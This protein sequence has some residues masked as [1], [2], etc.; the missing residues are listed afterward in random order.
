MIRPQWQALRVGHHVLVHDEEMAGMPLVP[1]RVA[2]IQTDPNSN[3]IGIRITPTEGT[4]KI[5]RPRR[6]AVH[7]PQLDLDE[8]CWRCATAA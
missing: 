6:L 8:H 1:G 2:M 7:M 5:V 4:S 3:D